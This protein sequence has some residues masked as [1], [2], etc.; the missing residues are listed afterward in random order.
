[1]S[2]NHEPR[3]NS[4]SAQY[5]TQFAWAEEAVKASSTIAAAWLQKPADDG[6]AILLGLFY[7]RK[8]G[9]SRHKAQ[10]WRVTREKDGKVKTFFMGSA[11]GHTEAYRRFYQPLRLKVRAAQK[12]A[13]EAAM[14]AGI[15]KARH[16]ADMA[17]RITVGT[18]SKNDRR[19]LAVAT[20]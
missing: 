3:G 6:S 11:P 1:M 16:A 8:P 5:R 13:K 20:R 17:A 7:F 15:A 18:P 12:Q 19:D 9:A 4:R 2:D 10:V 14:A